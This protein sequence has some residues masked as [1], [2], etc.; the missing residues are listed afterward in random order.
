MDSTDPL[1][2]V[3]GKKA[4]RILSKHMG[5]SWRFTLREM[6]FTDGAI[7]QKCSAY[8]NLKD[9][10][11]EIVYLSLLEWSRKNVDM[12]V[13][14]LCTFLWAK[15]QRECVLE[16]KNHLKRERKRNVL[17]SSSTAENGI[18]VESTKKSTEDDPVLCDGDKWK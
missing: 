14:Q 7:D 15:E 13:G 5:A 4:M 16:F 2:G 10:V 6:G 9:G 17:E 8:L 3:V 1:D 18:D 11:F 12:T